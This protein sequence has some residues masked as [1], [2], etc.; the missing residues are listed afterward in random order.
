[1]LTAVLAGLGLVSGVPLAVVGLVVLALWK[2]WLVVIGA[3]GWAVLTRLRARAD[4]P[5]ADDEAAFLRA[6]AAEMSSGAS[7]RS[8][9]ATAVDQFPGLR[10]EL[11]GRMAR[12][13]IAAHRIAD[14]LSSARPVNGRL[15]GAA[16]LLAA[17]SGGPAAAVAQMIAVLSAEH[18]E[19]ARERK[20]LT[21]QARASAW[22]VAAIPLILLVATIGS[23]RVSL[24]DPGLMPILAAGIAMQAAGVAI[25]VT[26]LRRS[27]R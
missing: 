1:M 9:L 11:A 20:A 22:V 4:R 3:T 24:D 26:M 27:A 17:R 10:L 12:S 23:G 16:W 14:V 13:G 21:A 8:A 19:L 7:L 5:S 15:A 6:F 25:V 18:G 2:P